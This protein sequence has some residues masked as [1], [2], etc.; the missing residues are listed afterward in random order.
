MLEAVRVLDVSHR[1][2]WLAGRLL[3]DLGADVIRLEGPQV[4]IESPD[5]Q[6]HHVNKRL[7]RLDLQAPAGRMA[8]DRLLAGIDILIDSTQPQDA[9][10]DIFAWNRLKTLNPR[11]IQVS[12]TPF[13]CQGPRAD[14]LASDLELM[15][16]G[17]AMSLAGE[18]DGSPVRVSVPQSGGW[19]GAQAAIG[20]LTALLHRNAGGAGQHVDVSAQAAVILATSHAA[21][22]WDVEGINPARC[23]AYLTGRSIKGARYRAFW[24]CADGYLNFMVYGGPA[25]RRTNT[26]LVAWMRE[27]GAPLGILEEINWQ[28]FDPKLATQSD[29]DAL[30]GPIAEFFLT[31]SKREFLEEASRREMLG[32]PVSTMADIATDP[33]LAARHFWADMKGRDGRQQRH[34]GS[35]AVIDGKRPPLRHAPGEE[36]DISALLSGASGPASQRSPDAGHVHAGGLSHALA[37]VKIAEFG[38]YA[39]GPH[40][41]KMLANFGAT[42]VHVESKSRPDGFRSEYPPFKGGKPGV[43]RSGC[44]A[45]FNDSKRAVTLDL[46]NEAGI[47]MAKRLIGWA[48]I[49]IENMR[50]EVMSRLGLGY[51]AAR[52]INPGVVMISS[53][54][55]GQTGPR[56][57]TPGFGSQLS[58][59][60]GFCGLT[61]S[62]DG[63]PQLLYGPYIDFVAS[64]LGASAVLAGLDRQRRSGQGALIDLAQYES[65]LMFIAGSLFDYHQHNVVAERAC[66]RDPLAAPH[67]AYPCRDGAWLALS[68]WSDDEFRRLA[69]TI[70][71]PALE[72]DPR[73]ATLAARQA[74]IEALNI[75]IE[76]WS[77][78]HDANEA[79]VQLQ[80]A[81]VHAYPVNTMADLFT[82]SQLLHRRVWRQR[83]HGV[84]GD[85]ACYFSSFDLSET[86]GDVTGAA[87]LLGADNEYVFCEL[88]DLTS[89]QYAHY[90]DLGAFE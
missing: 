11:L 25:G 63:P 72:R 33:Q 31:L 73:F 2:G 12:V 88:L 90:R 70:H 46:K 38:A 64:S 80:A 35:F 3:A 23:G 85:I 26:Q 45:I 74:N 77:S 1:V 19:A 84:M 78:V 10:A 87:P 27:R 56:A 60:A 49:V 51:E 76:Q 32:Y 15:A 4:D 52:R 30:E 22:F 41:G 83:R 75:I 71:R 7:L 67:D 16:A 89:E 55:M 37:G 57:Q 50:P 29:V 40:I 53:C 66:N 79:A 28:R 44:F 54:N 61:G 20:A 14:W 5:W 8:L 17:G 36:I 9:N 42:V 18:P 21:A 48:D 59:L 6:A 81:D 65:G 58:A 24:P 86:P 82:D 39:A 43:N 47:E 13:G 62:P 34:C 68:C 69:E